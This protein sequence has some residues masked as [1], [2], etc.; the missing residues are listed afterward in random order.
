MLLECPRCLWLY[1]NENIKRPFGIFP[2]LPGG[3][4][5]LFKKYF[6]KYRRLG[7]LP[8]EIEGKVKGKLFD[9]FDKLKALREVNFGKGG[10]CA[11]FSDLDIELRGAIDELLINDKGEYIPFDFKTRGYP[12]KDD[13]H[14][15]YQ[16]QLDL[17]S[18]LFEKNDMKSANY[19]YL[20]FFWPK[21]YDKRSA[22]FDTELK[23]LE[24]S[25]KKGMEILHR[26]RSIVDAEKPKSHEK[27][28]YC[29]YRQGFD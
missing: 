6:D 24:V 21:G 1:A 22:S 14:K 5:E 2:S 13:T 12:T 15:H 26:V 3:M 29:L 18:L 9:D 25:P 28:E 27:C 23:K 10:L 8:P 7:E 19:G 17:Y 4:D 11:Q 20:L 16:Y